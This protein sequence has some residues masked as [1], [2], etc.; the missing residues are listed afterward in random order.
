MTPNEQLVH[1]F[2]SA[3]QRKDWQA[4]A[5]CYHPEATFS[6]PVFPG[7]R[8]AE[9]GAMWHMLVT[10]GTDLQ[11]EF[12]KP[13]T[14][15]EA[16][17]CRW[18]ARYTFSKTGRKVENHVSATLQFRDGKITA[19]RDVFDLWRWCRMALGTTGILLGWSGLIR[20]KV[21]GMARKNLNQFM[22]KNGYV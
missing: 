3:F 22:Q 4:M 14:R 6:D 10:A 1:N 19:H 8:G 2:Y 16:V 11:L 17:I 9:V 18:I 15:D 20:G 13:V 5:A 21:R 12:E 7:L